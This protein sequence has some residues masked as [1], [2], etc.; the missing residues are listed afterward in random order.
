LGPA[1]IRTTSP[2]SSGEWAITGHPR[3][4]RRPDDSPPPGD[5][6]VAAAD[7]AADVVSDA[8]GAVG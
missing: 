3:R 5:V 2:P 8:G 1:R 4:D 7:A 6:D